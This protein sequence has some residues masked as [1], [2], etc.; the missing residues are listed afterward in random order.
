MKLKL[1]A[2]FVAL[3]FAL[4]SLTDLRAD[5]QATFVVSKFTFTRPAKWEWVENPSQF[6]KAQLKVTG[7]ATN[8]TAEVV[9]FEFTGG[10]GSVTANVERWHHQFVEPRTETNS[11][12]ETSIVGKTKVTYVLDEGTYNSGMPGGVTTPMSDYALSG[13]I[14][15]GDDGNI[16]VRMTGPKALVKASVADFKKMIE[17]A[18]K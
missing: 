15:E 4:I 1:S 3:I 13:V 11:K 17:S 12:V 2:P 18:L 7:S 5:D 8:I 6:R 16:F 14:I 9:F 10:A